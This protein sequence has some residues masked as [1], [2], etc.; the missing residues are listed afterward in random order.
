MPRCNCGRKN[1]SINIISPTGPTGPVG[2]TG[3]FGGPTGPTGAPGGPTGPTGPSSSFLVA[4]TVFVDGTYGSPAGVPENPAA[5]FNTIAGAQAAIPNDGNAW[6]VLIKPGDYDETIMPLP[7][8]IVTYEGDGNLAAK[9]TAIDTTGSDDC[10]ADFF[11]LKF[12]GSSDSPT[13]LAPT[14]GIIL[15]ES[16]FETTRTD[17]VADSSRYI[18]S[19]TGAALAVYN[20][21][22][23]AMFAGEPTVVKNDFIFGVSGDSQFIAEGNSIDMRDNSENTGTIGIINDTATAEATVRMSNN[24]STIRHEGVR[25]VSTDIRPYQLDTP[26]SEAELV[27]TNEYIDIRDVEGANSDLA[28]LTVRDEGTLMS[29]GHKVSNS[30][31][32]I[33]TFIDMSAAINGTINAL[34]YIKNTDQSVSTVGSG[35]IRYTASSGAGSYTTGGQSQSIVVL[36]ANMLLTPEYRTIILAAEDM[37]ITLPQTSVNDGLIFV[38]SNGGS[39]SG[40]IIAAQVPDSING[41]ADL[42]LP[43]INDNVTLQAHA[44]TSNWY[45]I[46]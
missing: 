14:G 32:A 23:N 31:T 21:T 37:L 38:L 4:R 10:V 27:V 7:G 26:D 13:V 45:I 6:K 42:S 20:S 2:P 8:R 11:N 3:A 16:A 34:G 29:Q 36:S 9:I 43:G 33:E 46:S 35:D 17:S 5:P 12:V 24:T 39:G 40:T 25:D 30:R 22:F 28:I 41:E 44:A 18:V 1:C 19:A 15:R